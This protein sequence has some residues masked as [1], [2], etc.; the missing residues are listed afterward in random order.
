VTTTPRI[1]TA[2]ATLVAA[3]V[4]CAA[5]AGVASAAPRIDPGASSTAPAPR[6]NPSGA[7]GASSSVSR[8]WSGYSVSGGTYTSVTATWTQRA[9]AARSAE[10]YAAFWVGLDG[11]GS[12]TVE[13]IGTMGYTYAGS[14]HYVAWYEMYPAAMQTLSLDVRPGDVCTAT[15]RWTGS[16][17]YRLTLQN[18]TTGKS[19]TV[20]QTSS[21]ALRS[22]AEVIAEAPADGSGVLPLATFGLATFSGCAV[23]GDSLAAAGASSIDMVDSGGSVI[24]ATSALS[25]DGTGFT[26]TDDFTAPAVTATNLQRTATSGWKNA[27]VSVKLRGS[28]GTG[29][30]GIAAVYYTVDGGATREYSGAFTIS[31]ADTHRVKYWA[32][33]RAGNTSGSRTG[34]VNLDLAAPTSAPGALTVAR[35]AAK[36]GATVAV[37]VTLSD[38]LPSS[39]A[40]TLVT[41]V[42]NSSGKTVAKATR[43]GVAANATRTVR[44]HPTSSLKK[45]AYTV[46]TIA[47]DAAGNV[48]TRAG[49]AQLTVR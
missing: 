25:A 22:S 9:V 15:V 29:G 11:D 6:I 31:E 8:N 39:G 2:L 7:H 1:S 46:R 49:R 34:Y 10:T 21:T 32:T 33:D 16:A 24:A 42:V 17:S 45:G 19:S 36:R 20:N 38:P 28:D 18:Q 5:L 30:S 43:T 40:V 4:A 47:T 48:Q 23:D 3:L 37:P 44:V 41:Q 14:A 13:Q 35:G 27:A 26:V 12:D